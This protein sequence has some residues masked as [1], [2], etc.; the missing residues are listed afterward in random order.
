MVE[1]LEYKLA[2][3]S[4][5]AEADRLLIEQLKLKVQESNEKLAQ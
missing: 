2:K 3:L 1:S 4:E 5:Q